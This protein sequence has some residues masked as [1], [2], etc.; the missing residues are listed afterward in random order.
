MNIVVIGTGY[1]GLV[2][3]AGFSEMG[4][5]VTCV[6]SDETKIKS[7]EAGRLPIYEPGL[8]EL[9]SRNVKESRLRFSSRLPQT[10]ADAH[11][12]VIAVGTP[13]NED[14]S[15]DLGH[16]MAVARELGQN[17]KEP[18]TIVNKSTVPIGTVDK[19]RDVIQAELEKRGARV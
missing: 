2:T 1:V 3:G 5:N 10:M 7:I 13:S 12:F 15:A 14:G 19:V 8:D 16:V 6:D 9:V 18:A 4:N 17:L 11:V